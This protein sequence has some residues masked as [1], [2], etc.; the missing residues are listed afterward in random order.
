MGKTETLKFFLEVFPFV[1][2]SYRV[3]DK[4]GETLAG[5]GWCLTARDKSLPTLQA[6]QVLRIDVRSL[7]W[8]DA[9]AAVRAGSV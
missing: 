3:R 6:F 9:V 4:I 5:T 1:G 2:A 8:R 7:F